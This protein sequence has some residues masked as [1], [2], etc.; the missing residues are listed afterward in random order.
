MEKKNNSITN[1]T[2]ISLQ[3][4]EYAQK[5]LTRIYFEFTEK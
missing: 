1:L 2:K 4:T 3:L 5:H